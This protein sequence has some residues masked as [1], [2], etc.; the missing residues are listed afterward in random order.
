MEAGA[1]GG[2][3]THGVD[4]VSV[5]PGMGLFTY[6]LLHGIHGYGVREKLRHV[7]P[8][9]LPV[10][11]CHQGVHFLLEFLVLKGWERGRSRPVG[12]A[13]RDSER[14]LE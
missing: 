4:T 12:D 3:G 8:G 14:N 1:G 11:A 6:L 10:F 9:R 7:L 5:A 13:E 2:L